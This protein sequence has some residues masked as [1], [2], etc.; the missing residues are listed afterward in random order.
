MC[1]GPRR[2]RMPASRS[3]RMARSPAAL[4]GCTVWEGCV[5]LGDQLLA[6]FLGAKMRLIGWLYMGS[7]LAPRGHRTH[8]SPAPR[9]RSSRSF[10]WSLAWPE[11]LSSRVTA[12]YERRTT[13][14]PATTTP[15]TTPAYTYSPPVRSGGGQRWC[16]GHH[17]L[18]VLPVESELAAALLHTQPHQRHP[19]PR[20]SWGTPR[21]APRRAGPGPARSPQGRRW[22]ATAS[23]W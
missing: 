22:T 14:V 4:V 16:S 8:P 15:A 21:A 20:L 19:W 23:R 6:W 11:V 10:F 7:S 13:V 9:E 1:R 3:M 18:A 5:W 12:P 2:R 17:Q